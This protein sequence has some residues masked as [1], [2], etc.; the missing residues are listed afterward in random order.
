MADLVVERTSSPNI[1]THSP[2]P[3]GEGSGYFIRLPAIGVLPLKVY[4]PL[5]LWRGA[6]GEAG[7]LHDH[8]VEQAV[9]AEG[10]AAFVEEI[11]GE[12]E[13]DN[14]GNDDGRGYPSEETGI[15]LGLLAASLCS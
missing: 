14:E 11:D 1:L 8:L 15:G 13:G 3:R 4:T 6:R 12:D 9:L 5:S 7:L 10:L 2:S